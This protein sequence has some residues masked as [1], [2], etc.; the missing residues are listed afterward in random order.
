MFTEVMENFIR[1]GSDLAC[2]TLVTYAQRNEISEANLA[3]L[4]RRL[5]ESGT[6]LQLPDTLTC[7]DIPSTGGPSSLSTLLC[8]LFMVAMG[9]AVPKLSVPGR[10]AG[11][12]DVL[13]Q[14][15]GYRFTF[16]PQE[17]ID[18]LEQCG[19]VHF[20]ATDNFAPRD[21]ELYEYRKRIGALHLPDLVIASLLSKKL[22]V[23]LMRIGLDIRF[24]S[25]GNFGISW[26]EAR[27]NA[28]KFIRVASLLDIDAACFITNGQIPYQPYIGRGE[29]LIAVHNILEGTVDEWLSR[30]VNLC[31]S[32]ARTVAGKRVII[33]SLAK[34]SVRKIFADHLMAHGTSNEAFE[35]LVTRMRAVKRETV[36]AQ[37]EGFVVIKLNEIRKHMVKAQIKMATSESPFP[38]P[39]GVILLKNTGDYVRKGDPIATIR[40]DADAVYDAIYDIKQSL[41]VS[42]SPG[43]IGGYEEVRNV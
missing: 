16:R 1:D 42:N 24:A 19:Y 11:G 31:F 28:H 43:Q 21:G 30:H 10:P 17:I 33:D 38:D 6:I 35:D 39:V 40:S 13:A 26:E 8:P 12:I 14:I 36:F 41:S 25:H 23:G 32:M 9:C 18:I 5:A 3:Q 4:A 29:A 27:K 7:A 15:P 34:E 22:A 20:L 37:E 2:K